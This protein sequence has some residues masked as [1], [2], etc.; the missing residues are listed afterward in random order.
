MPDKVI[1][2]NMAALKKKYGAAGVKSI[3]S[4][5]R[6]LIAADK[7]RGLTTTLVA[8][9]DAAA[10]RKL[11]ATPVR[12]PASTQE[13]KEAVDGVYKALV[14]DY[15]LILGATDVIPHQDLKNP[16]YK[17][18]DDG[19]PDAIAYGD[20]PYA[21]DAP[22][23]QDVKEFTGPTRVV[24][25]LPDLTGAKGSPKYLLGLLKTAANWKASAQSDYQSYFGISAQTWM[26]STAQSLTNV[27]SYSKDMQTS[28]SKGYKWKPAFINRRMHFINCHGGDTFPDFLGQS[29][30]NSDD[31]PVSHMA[32]FVGA[33][34]N[35][36]EGTIVSAEC[37]YGGQLYDPSAIAGQMGICNTYLERKAYAFFGSTTTAYGPTKGND[38]ADLICQYFLQAVLTGA[39]TGRAALEARQ[40][41]VEKSSPLSPINQKT[42]A[43]FNLYGDPAIAPVVVE[44]PHESVGPKARAAI[45][46]R[47]HAR[48][49]GAKSPA[50]YFIDEAKA[51][52]IAQHRAT[53]RA[54]GALL[55][56]MQPSMTESESGP[57]RGVRSSLSRRM[58]ELN[59]RPVHAASFAVASA[60][61][62]SFAS[63]SPLSSA[64]GM[65]LASKAPSV[66]AF[67]VMIGK[68]PEREAR[69]ES[70]Q[71]GAAVK[72]AA[73]EA[74]GARK[75]L[76]VRKLVVLEAKEVD[77]KIV[78][79]IEAHSK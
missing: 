16:L 78:S 13:N 17:A 30:K 55:S 48:A 18:G 68:R 76:N 2:T 61:P 44:S 56:Q 40:R 14:P 7:R 8:I 72:D 21:C 24:G 6:D 4:A 63:A 51:A 28:P 27:F 46:K 37:C 29:V 5:V 49:S 47:V 59:C 39:S 26:Q 75:R 25:R 79:I 74:D 42:L 65:S 66:T 22:Y 19:D 70:P 77:G 15:L 60:P 71:K 64:A 12:N 20:V 41:F 62:R 53:L 50:A 52:E 11:K 58:G 9:D 34:G 45:R 33:K 57:P 3:Q 1:V 38:Q 31:Y 69:A 67:H 36:V 23:G 10:M 32:S 35:I 54:K 73:G 43:Q